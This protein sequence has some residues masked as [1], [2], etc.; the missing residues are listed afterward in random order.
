MDGIGLTQRF[1]LEKAQPLLNSIFGT[2]LAEMSVALIGNGSEVLGF[3]DAISEDHN[4]WPRLN[5]FLDD[6]HYSV[7]DARIEQQVLEQLP[8][9]FEGYP[10]RRNGQ[11]PSISFSP[12]NEFFREHLCASR[13]PLAKNDWFMINEQHLLELTSASIFHDPSSRLANALGSIRFYPEEFEPLLVH[14]AL[15][16]LSEV[17]GIERSIQREDIISASFYF[18]Q[19]CYFAIRL[20]HLLNRKYCPYPKWMG[21]SV[22]E[23]GSDGQQVYEL[24][25]DGFSSTEPGA[26][27]EAILDAW[28][29]LRRAFRARFPSPKEAPDESTA[30]HLLHLPGIDDMADVC[31]AAIPHQLAV[32][33]HVQPP[34]Y[35]GQ[36]FDYTGYDVCFS[37]LLLDHLNTK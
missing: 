16:R 14:R 15:E 36:L 2:R 28:G 3:D 35:W 37:K 31:E 25:C 18:G 34:A 32:P 17:G 29:V 12:L 4:F 23:L 24:L 21:R 5:I 19:F 13:F 30:L 10:I 26:Y 8:D 11:Y 22:R 7:F 20:L 33:F 27:R 9:S 6:N 1:W